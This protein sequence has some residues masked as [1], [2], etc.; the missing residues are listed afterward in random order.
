[1]HNWI[2]LGKFGK[3]YGIKGWAKVISYTLPIVKILDYLPWFIL[4]DDN[5]ELIPTAKGKLH[6]DQLLVKLEQCH[7]RDSIKRYTNLDIH[8]Q[9]EQLPAPAENE[10]YWVD[11]IGLTI[12][13]KEGV[14]LGKV[15]RVFDTGA[16]DVLAVKDEHGKERYI[17]YIDNVILNVDL[18]D[19]TIHVDWD[20]D[21]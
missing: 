8:I 9:R 16:N 2:I 6:G 5:V 7:D 10:I 14:N 12:L 15:E 13:N 4:H 11:L 1:M 20:A 18:N 3:P 21:F 17:P 19:R